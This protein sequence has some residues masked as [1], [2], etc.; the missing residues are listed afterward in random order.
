M[1]M[2]RLPSGRFFNVETIVTTEKE[3][4]HQGNA[5][6][7][8]LFT[9]YVSALDEDG[10]DVRHFEGADA[11]ALYKWLEANA[12]AIGEDG[13]EVAKVTGDGFPPGYAEFLKALKVIWPFG[14]SDVVAYDDYELSIDD[15]G[16]MIDDGFILS[17]SKGYIIRELGISMIEDD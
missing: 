5:G 7:N 11:R 3:I 4:Y 9:V 16:S 17:T 6:D 12:V 10:T 8:S 15:L 14:L 2:L 13:R 1:Q